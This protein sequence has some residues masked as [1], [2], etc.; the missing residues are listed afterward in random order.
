MKS[1]QSIFGLMK[2]LQIVR[3][4]FLGGMV[5]SFLII[6]IPLFTLEIIQTSELQKI[7]LLVRFFNRISCKKGLKAKILC[8]FLCF[9]LFNPPETGMF[10]NQKDRFIPDITQAEEIQKSASIELRKWSEN[11]VNVENCQ[12]LKENC[13]FFP[14]I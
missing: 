2:A 8:F 4:A 7:F 13:E 14:V 9:F 11:V 6:P 12:F 1:R 5:L 10:Q 3:K